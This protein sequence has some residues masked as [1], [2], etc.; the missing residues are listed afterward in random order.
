MIKTLYNHDLQTDG[1]CTQHNAIAQ[2]YLSF[3][4]DN[5]FL[6]ASFQ[7]F[8]PFIFQNTLPTLEYYALKTEACLFRDTYKMNIKVEEKFCKFSN[9]IQSNFE[10]SIK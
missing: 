9:G 6:I 1:V 5:T 8:F 2:F 4:T 10:V 3:T 7:Y